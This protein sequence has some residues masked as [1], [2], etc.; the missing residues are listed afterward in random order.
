MFLD[1]K[2]ITTHYWLLQPEGDVFHAYLALRTG[3]NSVCAE[4]APITNLGAMNI[5]GDRSLCC[6]RCFQ[7]LYGINLS[8]SNIFAKEK[9]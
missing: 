7:G 1:M 2:K 6:A 8:G 4:V 9:I 3:Q 5:P